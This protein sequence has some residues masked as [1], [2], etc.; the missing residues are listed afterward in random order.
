MGYEEKNVTIPGNAISKKEYT[1][2][3]LNEFG[4]VAKLTRGGAP[5]T[6]SDNGSNMMSPTR[7]K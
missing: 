3:N 4:S 1:A 7:P 5:S 2:P 6:N